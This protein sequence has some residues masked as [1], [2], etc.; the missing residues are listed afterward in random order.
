MP[1][2]SPFHRT[3]LAIALA[4]L[5]AATIVIHPAMA[6]KVVNTALQPEAAGATVHPVA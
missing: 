3:A 1:S 4:L 5:A 6:E 2:P